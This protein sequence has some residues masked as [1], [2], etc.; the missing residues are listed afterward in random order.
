L[1][2]HRQINENGR[3]T[4]LKLSVLAKMTG[5]MYVDRN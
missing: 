3:L 5:I 4:L 1:L 2:T